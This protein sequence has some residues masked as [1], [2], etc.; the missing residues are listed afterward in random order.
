MGKKQVAR[1]RFTKWSKALGTLLIVALS[2][3]LLLTAVAC[4]S[5]GAE[6]GSASYSGSI[7]ESGQLTQTGS[8]PARLCSVNWED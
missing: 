6:V 8:A 2:A 4:S 7:V 3:T 1:L 5:G